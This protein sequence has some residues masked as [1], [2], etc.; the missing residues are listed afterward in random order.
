VA[1]VLTLVQTKQIRINMYIRVTLYGGNL[2]ILWLFHLGISCTVVALTC[3]VVAF[4]C[5]V[6]CGCFGNMCTCMHCVLYCFVYTWMRLYRQ[7][8]TCCAACVELNDKDSS[9]MSTGPICGLLHSIH[10]MYTA[11]WVL[12]MCSNLKMTHV[13]RNTLLNKQQILYVLMTVI[14]VQGL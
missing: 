2:I 11:L 5:F 9:I 13:S 10:C 14:Y 1:V 3:T 12:Y 7:P 8:H 4:T 6:L